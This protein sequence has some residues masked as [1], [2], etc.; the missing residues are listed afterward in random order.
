MLLGHA[1]G[2]LY[3]QECDLSFRRV[4]E[5]FTE[6]GYLWADADPHKNEY[7]RWVP[8]LPDLPRGANAL[9]KAR[10]KPLKEKG[11]DAEDVREL[12]DEL[13]RLGVVVRDQKRRQYVRTLPTTD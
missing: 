11:S 5:A 7:R 2:E 6:H 13:A 12:R 10:Q 9:L 3:R 8:D 1:G 4:A